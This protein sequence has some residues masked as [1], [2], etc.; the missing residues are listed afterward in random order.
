MVNF[1]GVYVFVLL[2]GQFCTN[3]HEILKQAVFLAGTN[4]LGHYFCPKVPSRAL[5]LVCVMLLMIV[6]C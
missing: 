1:W 2:R 5:W 3:F 6:R 4:I